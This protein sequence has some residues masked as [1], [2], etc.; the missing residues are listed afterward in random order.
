[1][2]MKYHPD[3]VYN[4]GAEYQKDAQEKFKKINEAYEQI[5]KEEGNKLS[6][7]FTVYSLRFAWNKIVANNVNPAI[8]L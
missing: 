8:W 6:L 1:M 5:K 7:R 4:L 2:A 3:K